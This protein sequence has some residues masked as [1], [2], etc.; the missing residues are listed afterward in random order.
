MKITERHFW[1]GVL[2]TV[3]IISLIINLNVTLKEPL[4]FGDE[5]WWASKGEW[6]LHHLTI[7]KY[8]RVFSPSP[9]FKSF[10]LEQPL[11]MF[12]LSSCF[13]IGGETLVKAINPILGTLLA[14]VT[15]LFVRRV[16]SLRAAVLSA[17]FLSMI[18]SFIT[19]EVLLY[20][21]VFAIL[22]ATTSIYLLYRAMKEDDR[23]YLFLILSGILSGMAAITEVSSVAM[24]IVFLGLLLLYRKGWLK[25]FLITTIVFIIVI[26]PLYGIHN[27]LMLGNPGLPKEDLIGNFPR[28]KVLKKIPELDVGA[29]KSPQELG[30]GTG[31]TILK[32]GIINYIQ[33]AYGLGVFIFASIGLSYLLYKRNRK[34]LMIMYWFFI[35]LVL[36]F[37]ANAGGRAEDAARNMLY[38]VVPFAI[39]AG[40]GAEK[41]YEFL[42]GYGESSGKVVA[43]IFVFILLCF[44]LFSIHAKAESLRP[45]K[46]FSP[47]FFKGCDWIRRN[48][49]SDALLVNLWGHRAEYACKRDSVYWNAPG[50]DTMLLVGNDTSYQIMKDLGVD[51]VYIQKFSISP[52]K[53]RVSYPWVFVKYVRNSNHF[54]KVYEYPENCMSS[55]IQDCVVVYKVL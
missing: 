32:M 47:A 45:I 1:Y 54:K 17:V 53:E 7:P 22:L 21:E 5:G 46:E 55:N 26:T 13:A 19:Y 12:L 38:T 4:V 33:F 37:Y 11:L 31:A 25:N 14:L 49:P 39:I 3:L 42:K 35:I 29:P 8:N 51:Y 27:Y 48:T 16:Y 15:F 40:I 36:T 44:S 30:I 2:F 41:I 43:V 50:G 52:G 10:F 18:P 9:A 24:P 23:R 28:E 20:A 34:N 6:I